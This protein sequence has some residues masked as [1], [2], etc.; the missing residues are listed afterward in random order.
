MKYVSAKL[1]TMR[2]PQEFCVRPRSDG[3]IHIQS[4]TSMGYFDPATGEGVLNQ[5]GNTFLHDSAALG[6]REITYPADFVAECV[7][8]LPDPNGETTL[9]GGAILMANMIK[10]I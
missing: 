2:K 8:A 10:V 5:R 7:A 1:G 9:A 4:D 3:K 6:A